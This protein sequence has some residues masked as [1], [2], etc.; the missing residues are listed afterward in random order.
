MKEGHP[1]ADLIPIVTNHNDLVTDIAQNGVHEPVYLFE[2]KVIEGRVRQA[3]CREV[4]VQP[5]YKD[6]VLLDEGNDPL[7]W[8]IRRHVETHDVDE[9]A[10]IS[11]AVA[12]L[13][14]FEELKGSTHKQVADATGLSQHKVRYVDWLVDARAIDS[15]LNG[16]ET[17]IDAARRIGVAPDKRG[18]ALGKSYGHGDK[19]DEATQPLKRYLAAWKRKGYEFRHLNPKEAS[20]RLSLITQLIEE[21]E[22]TKP[23]LA[24]RAVTATLS[25]PAERRR[26]E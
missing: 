13:P 6:W 26:R 20:R 19:F 22:A 4:G 7:G 15:V 25:A 12:A 9:I 14:H 2:Q 18:S 1:L 24:R 8:M 17:L 23:D 16:A 5:Q 11:L 21:L 3:A 10:R